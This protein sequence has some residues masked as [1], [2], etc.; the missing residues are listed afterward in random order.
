MRKYEFCKC[1]SKR[2]DQ[3]QVKRANPKFQPSTHLLGLYSSRKTL[4]RGFLM[5]QFDFADAKLIAVITRE[6]KQITIDKS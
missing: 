5:M 4:K 3:L 6:F 1:K 2:A